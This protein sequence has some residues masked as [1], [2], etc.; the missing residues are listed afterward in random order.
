MLKILILT[1]SIAIVGCGKEYNSASLPSGNDNNNLGG[2]LPADFP[3]NELIENNLNF[4]SK[5]EFKNM[6]VPEGL[7][8]TEL[9]SFALALNISSTFEGHENWKN[10]TNNFDG[11]G[12]SMGL[13]NQTLGTES[14]QPLLLEML[15]AH[16]AQMKK[17]FSDNN[18]KS[19]EQMILKWKDD[20]GVRAASREALFAEDSDSISILDE[21]VRMHIFANAG[22]HSVDW[23]VKTIYTDTQGKKFKTDWKSQLQTLCM[24]PEYRSVQFEAARYLHEKS[25]SYFERF[26]LKEIRSYL[27][28][29]DVVVQNGGFYQ[30]NLAE[31]QDFMIKNPRATESQKLAALLKSR[32]VQ[33]K[34]QFKED[35]KARKQSLIDG[36]GRVHSTDR[37]YEKEYCYTSLSPL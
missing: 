29:F 20:A 35:V 1:I 26:Q 5:L 14:L 17:Q 19:L 25:K 11:Q 34:D 10:I 6:K 30:R 37:N 24:T 9:N 12:L 28:L 27:F 8:L 23:A 21:D 7:T 32:L 15:Q 31:F 13:L 22:D 2:E 18:F 16:K 36:F 3:E 4:C 33:V